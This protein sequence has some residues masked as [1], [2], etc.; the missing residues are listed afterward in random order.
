MY[1]CGSAL[2]CACLYDIEDLLNEDPILPCA[3]I[4]GPRCKCGFVCTFVQKCQKDYKTEICIEG[5]TPT[6]LE[7]GPNPACV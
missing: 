3:V 5:T 6:S 2:A 1:S 4:A 7:S